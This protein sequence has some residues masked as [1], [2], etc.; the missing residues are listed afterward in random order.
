MRASDPGGRPLTGLTGQLQLA[1]VDADGQLGPLLPA[2]PLGERAAGLYE[3]RVP[4]GRAAAVLAEARLDDPA[5]PA[6]GA[7]QAQGQL[8]LPLAPDLMPDGSAAGGHAVLEDIARRTGG[9]VLGAVRPAAETG[10]VASPGPLAHPRTDPAAAP[11]GARRAG[12]FSCGRRLT[13]C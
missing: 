7:F 5:A 3:A 8:S 10:V 11:A 9:Q 13:P 4:L 12:A 6:G 1:W 2:A